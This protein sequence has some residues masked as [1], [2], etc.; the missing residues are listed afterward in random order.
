ME[1][2]PSEKGRASVFVLEDGAARLAVTDF[3][4]TILEFGR[5]D[6]EGELHDIVLGFSEL[7]RYKENPACYG[8]TVG[9]VA[10]RTDQAKIELGGRTFRLEGNDG[11]GHRNN[12]HS[13]LTGGLQQRLWHVEDTSRSRVHLSVDLSDGE[14]GLPGNRRFEALFSLAS[15]DGFSEA[16]IC[17]RCTTDAPTFVNMTNHSYFN[18][19][20]A[21]AASALPTRVCIPASR[22]CPVREDM[23]PTGELAPVE[24]TPFDFRR[25]KPL[26][27]DIGADDEQL[28]RAHGYDHCFAIDGWKPD[29]ALRRALH[30]ENPASGYAL[31]VLSTMPG[32]QLYAGNWLD[33]TDMKGASHYG[34]HAGFAAEAEYFPNCANVAGWPKPRCTP[35]HPFEET[36]VFRL[37]G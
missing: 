26:G 21:G 23:V 36:V 3:G 9:P 37:E 22:F 4:A 35:E 12:L 17:Y 10:N 29:G 20:G 1:T 7:T 27:E 16:R 30:A 28:E 6:A 13:S 33:D 25:E 5:M 32:I 19:A 8:A 14:L 31:E 11:P 15:E 34:A 18:L 2:M 24:G